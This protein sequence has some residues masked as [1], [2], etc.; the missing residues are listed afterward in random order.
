M[1]LKT[2]KNLQLFNADAGWQKERMSGGDA[3]IS[4]L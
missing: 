3:K 1:I 4:R 2:Q